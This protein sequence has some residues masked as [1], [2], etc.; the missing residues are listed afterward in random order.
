MWDAPVLAAIVIYD[1]TAWGFFPAQ[2]ATRIGV[3]GLSNS[4]IVLS[5]NASFISRRTAEACVATKS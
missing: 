3:A 2:Q 5:L 4:A 1:S